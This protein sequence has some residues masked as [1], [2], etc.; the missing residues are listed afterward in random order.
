MPAVMDLGKQGPHPDLITNLVEKL[1][2]YPYQ[3]VDVVES[4][5]QVVQQR[6]ISE[7]KWSMWSADGTTTRS[8]KLDVSAVVA[9]SAPH[10]KRKQLIA[11]VATRPPGQ[12]DWGIAEMSNA[13]IEDPPKKP[14]T[15]CFLG[16]QGM[17]IG[18]GGLAHSPDLGKVR[19]TL[20]DGQTFESTVSGGSFLVLAPCGSSE[21]WS[22]P[23]TF[24]YYDNEGR[25]ILTDTYDLDLSSA[26]S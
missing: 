17:W 12:D 5:I 14:W 13:W 16:S 20:A 2:I 25:E 22:S 6:T 24:G 8:G 23:M 9:V 3:D 18:V 11:F 26:T 21:L 15:G 1:G 19:I 4:D 10:A 7:V